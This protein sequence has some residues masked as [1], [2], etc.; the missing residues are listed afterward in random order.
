MNKKEA[1]DKLGKMEKEFEEI[2]KVLLADDTVDLF[3]ITNYSEVCK[4]LGIKE[5]TVKDFNTL[6]EFRYHQIQNIEKLYND[7]W[8]PDWTNS[9]QYKYYP[10]FQGQKGSGLVFGSSSYYCFFFFGGVA[11]FRDRKTSDYVG[12]TF[13]EIYKDLM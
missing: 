1:I 2:K 3:T 5:K 7:G 13:I 8:K 11:Y 4:A 9:N 12:K 10:Y 6:K